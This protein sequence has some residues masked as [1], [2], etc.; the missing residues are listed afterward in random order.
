MIRP[1]K[2][3][4]GPERIDIRFQPTRVNAHIIVGRHHVVALWRHRSLV[5]ARKTCRGA[6]R[7]AA[8]PG[9]S[10]AASR[11]WASASSRSVSSRSAAVES[12]FETRRPGG[13][14]GVVPRGVPLS[15]SMGVMGIYPLPGDSRNRWC[16][17]RV[18]KFVHP[19]RILNL[20]R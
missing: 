4:A 12:G 18:E 7:T 8:E 14:G 11:H 20:K 16:R 6:A 19:V 3:A 5:S 13:V 2:T 10:P 1:P 15:R 9:S 17:W